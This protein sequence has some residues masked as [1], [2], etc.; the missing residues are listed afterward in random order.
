MESLGTFAQ[1]GDTVQPELRHQ[2]YAR[3]ARTQIELESKQLAIVRNVNQD[4]T[5]RALALISQRG[6]VMRGTTVPVD[7]I[8]VTPLNTGAYSS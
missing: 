2:S 4:S 8:A 3:L 6:H 5:V 1:Q 7:K